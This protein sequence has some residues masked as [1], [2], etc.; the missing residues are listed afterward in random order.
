M[1]QPKK[2]T[3]PNGYP[4]NTY[5]QSVPVLGYVEQPVATARLFYIEG[6]RP[7]TRS[8]LKPQLTVV[9]D[10]SNPLLWQVVIA[11]S[12]TATAD[13]PRL[14][15]IELLINR[16]LYATGILQLTLQTIP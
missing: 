5:R 1:N 9:N 6:G 16:Q 14:T 12:A 10:L 3:L 15:K 2:L 7:V 4:G 11:F 13:L 8:W